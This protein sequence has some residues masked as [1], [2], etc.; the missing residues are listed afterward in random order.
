M[1]EIRTTDWYQTFLSKQFFILEPRPEDVDVRDIAHHL[2]LQN[3]FGGATRVPYSVAEHSVRASRI[4][5]PEDALWALLHDAHEA[6]CQDVV[7]PL[8]KQLR[9]YGPI[10]DRMARTVAERFGLWSPMPASV[11]RADEIML[12]T[13]MRDLM[14]SPPAPWVFN[15]EV[16]PLA[17]TI[18]PWSW[19]EAERSFLR[20]FEELTGT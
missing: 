1:T 4:V 6:Y 18:Y 10:E 5:P 2:A 12:V 16:Q 14:G 17:Q 8:K 19:E 9:D 3:R 13:E 7:R 15:E 11:R 20:R